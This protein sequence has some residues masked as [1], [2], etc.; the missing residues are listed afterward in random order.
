MA[1]NLWN[2]VKKGLSQA[3]EKSEEITKVSTKK[4]EIAGLQ[5]NIKNAFTEL[6]AYVYA[7]H[8][9]EEKKN[10]V[11]DKEFKEKIEQIIQLHKL[12]EEKEKEL[13]NI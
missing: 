9:E 12:L 8:V 3:L 1:N 6:G 2:K 4:I 5:H 13:N 7:Y 10:L 11:K